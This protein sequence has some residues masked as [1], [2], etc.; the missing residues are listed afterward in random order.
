MLETVWTGI[1][2]RGTHAQRMTKF[3]GHATFDDV[4]QGRAT[5]EDRLG[6]N[7]ADTCATMGIHFASPDTLRRVECWLL[8]RQSL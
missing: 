6:N 3:K 8:R 7:E 2:R 1:L 5:T 4:D